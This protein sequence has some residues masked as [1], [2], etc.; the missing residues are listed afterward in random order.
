MLPHPLSVSSLKI[1]SSISIDGYPYP[2][3]CIRENLYKEISDDCVIDTAGGASNHLTSV[4]GVN[5]FT[6]RTVG[7]VW[8]I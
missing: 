6:E 4:Q 2:L 5:S 7:F 1:Q 8:T 3:I